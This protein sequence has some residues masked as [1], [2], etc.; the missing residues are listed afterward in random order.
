MTA[1]IEANE[2]ATANILFPTFAAGM[3]GTGNIDNGGMLSLNAMGLAYT[4]FTATEE[5]TEDE[6]TKNVGDLTIDTA[7]PI[8]FNHLT[9]NFTEALTSTADGGAD[10]TASWGGTPVVRPAVNNTANVEMISNDYQTLNG[11]NVDANGGGR[12]AEKDAGG[13]EANAFDDTITG[14]FNT[15]ANLEGE[16]ADTIVAADTD[17]P[18]QNPKW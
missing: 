4:K 11:L 14:Y 16:Q 2:T 18:R 17:G 1:A 3:D 8:A 15:G 10:Q 7:E 5:V 12:L 13:M 6:T 9:G